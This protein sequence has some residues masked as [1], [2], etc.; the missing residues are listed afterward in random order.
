MAKYRYKALHGL[1]A[2]KASMEISR[3][4][5]KLTVHSLIN[6]AERTGFR[7]T[8]RPSYGSHVNVARGRNQ[9]LDDQE[10]GGEGGQN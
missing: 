6:V 3:S 10:N 1:E 7:K 9:E 2:M 8:L 5:K 4:L